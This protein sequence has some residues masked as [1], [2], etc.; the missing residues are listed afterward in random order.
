M[1]KNN[2]KIQSETRGGVSLG[3]FQL[4]CFF[5]SAFRT[6]VR[7]ACANFYELPVRMGY[8]RNDLCAA[9]NGSQCR[10][11]ML[12][13]VRDCVQSPSLQPLATVLTGF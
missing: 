4:S 9:A 7:N 1:W 13:Q 12:K 2:M 11:Q 8:H 6:W 10:F 3:W 5:I